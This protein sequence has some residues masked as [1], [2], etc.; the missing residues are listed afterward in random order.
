[1]IEIAKIFSGRI[2]RQKKPD[3][4]IELLSIAGF[5]IIKFDKYEITRRYDS[6][7]ELVSIAQSFPFIKDFSKPDKDI[8]L[9]KF[10]KNATIISDPFIVVAI[11]QKGNKQNEKS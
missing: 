2:L 11:K 3:Y 7:Q 8:I 9:Q 1:L 5:Q 6:A 10:A 4:Y